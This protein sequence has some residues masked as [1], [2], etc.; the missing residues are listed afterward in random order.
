[1][2]ER[3]AAE[4]EERASVQEKR[5]GRTWVHET[6]PIQ[7]VTALRNLS[8]A[9]NLNPQD[10]EAAKL[11][12]DLLL[13]R[14]WCPPAEA[15]VRYQQDA[16]LAATFVRG[17]SNN[18][19]FAASGDG[20]LL[21]VHWKERALLPVKTY[22]KQGH[23]D[24]SLFKKPEPNDQQVVQPGFASF[25]PNGQWLLTV[26]PTVTLAAVTKRAAQGRPQA[27]RLPLMP[28]A[29]MSPVTFVL[30]LDDEK[31]HI[32]SAGPELA[33]QRLQGSGTMNF[34]WSGDSDRVLVTNWRSASDAK[35]Y[36]FDVAENGVRERPDRSDSLN[37]MKIVAIAFSP[38]RARI[39]A[40]S[41]ERKVMFIRRD[42]LQVIPKALNGNDSFQFTEGFQP[43]SVAFGPSDDELT[44]TSW[45]GIRILNVRDGKV[46]PIRP[47]TFRDQ[48]IRMVIG[49][50]DFAT[51][52]TAT[53]LNGRVEVAKSARM[54]E[55][56][57]PVVF[58]GSMGIPQF[59][60]DGKRL[61]ILSGGMLNV[62]DTIR[63]IDVS[64]LYRP[65]RARSRKFRTKTSASM[66]GRNCQRSQRIR[67]RRRW[68]FAYTGNCAERHPGKQSRRSLRSRL[69]AF[70]SG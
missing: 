44:L 38:D 21:R 52:L 49:S 39:A 69:E 51:R 30:A 18:E 28:V 4:A 8:A 37:G 1:M 24:G 58:R 36:L 27:V 6:K 33:I 20:Q 3:T 26:R 62:F 70:L 17:E 65:S 14:I 48:F 23:D 54:E 2:P 67:L 68:L 34:A 60:P 11:A 15:D 66:A 43:I 9:L 19:I 12:R 16:L 25:S 41:S 31:S 10:T 59:S 55:P 32:E 50:G 63:L 40:V 7:A 29:A 53:S 42:N 13:Q 56:A 64:P 35:C 57:E 5:Q 46:T 45:S 61:L 47:P 22:G